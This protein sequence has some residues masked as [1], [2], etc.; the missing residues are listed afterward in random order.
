[1]ST[2][3][4]AHEGATSAVNDGWVSGGSFLSSILAGTLLGLGL[5]A[6][7]DTSP[8]L[9]VVGVVAG[10]ISGFYGMRDRVTAVQG[11]QDLFDG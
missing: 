8:W 6:W 2:I 4:K 11:K 3:K 9:V 5:D 7:L 10:S 1:M